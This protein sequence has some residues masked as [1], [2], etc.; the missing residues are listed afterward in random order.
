MGA[1]AVPL[2]QEA[3]AVI[4]IKIRK[5][6]MDNQ[7]DA[8]ILRRCAHYV[9][10]AQDWILASPRRVS[11]D[12]LISLLIPV[13]CEDI[14]AGK[15]EVHASVFA[16]GKYRDSSAW[17][18]LERALE[19][20][21]QASA[22]RE[23]IDSI[24]ALPAD[25]TERARKWEEAWRVL[26]RIP[27][28]ETRNQLVNSVFQAVQSEMAGNGEPNG[29]QDSI[30]EVLRYSLTRPHEAGA[31]LRELQGTLL[32]NEA[33]LASLIT[34]VWEKQLFTAGLERLAPAT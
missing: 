21:R 16:D 2:S 12:A 6:E 3:F 31:A 7:T 5:A 34:F 14:L 33:Q 20:R 18:G 11:M 17:K 15:T 27:P 22:F 30:E 10:K 8:Y 32:C 23:H 4:Q 19:I 1:C 26:D 29:G 9:W 13:E 24:F 25:S 28:S